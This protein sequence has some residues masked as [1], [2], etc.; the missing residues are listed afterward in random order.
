MTR[1]RPDYRQGVR[2]RNDILL[3]SVVYSLSYEG[4]IFSSLH[5]QGGKPE[6]TFPDLKQVRHTFGTCYSG[7]NYPA[8]FF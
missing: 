7:R 3:L 2:N 1:L 6:K 5:R 4:E 8:I